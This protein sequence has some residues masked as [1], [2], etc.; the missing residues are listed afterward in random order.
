MELL[1]GLAHITKPNWLFQQR[2][3]SIQETSF[4]NSYSRSLFTIIPLITRVV[5]QS[6]LQKASKV[7]KAKNCIWPLMNAW[8]T[9]PQRELYLPFFPKKIPLFYGICISFEQFFKFV[10]TLWCINIYR[11]YSQ[12]S[13]TRWYIFQTV[14]FLVDK[15]S[16]S[17]MLM[18]IN[19]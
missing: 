8:T 7:R 4:K 11:Y 9:E 12:L 13:L 5:K 14:F 6:N 1:G 17:K 19:K 16:K 10:S 2:F 15:I 18:L 3:I